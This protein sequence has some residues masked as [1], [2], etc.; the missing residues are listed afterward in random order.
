ME[1]VN[2]QG[3]LVL[4]VIPSSLMASLAKEIVHALLELDEQIGAAKSTDKSSQHI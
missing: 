4:V 1:V 2:L 3:F